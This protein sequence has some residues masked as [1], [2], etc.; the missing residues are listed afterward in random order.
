MKHHALE[1]PEGTGIAYGRRGEGVAS[2]SND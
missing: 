1:P 2:G